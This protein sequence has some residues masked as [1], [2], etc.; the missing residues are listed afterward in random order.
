MHELA[1][2]Q[3]VVAAVRERLGDAPVRAVTL[4]VGA[5]SGVVPDSVRFCFDLCTEG[6]PLAGARL[7]VL[8]IPGR[9]NCRACGA[10]VAMADLF[11]LCP[12]GSADLDVRAGQ[13]LRIKQVEVA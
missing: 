5:L 12:C 1:I 9:G 11:P 7:D 3:S 10:D 4:E 8:E 2:T 13:E 6:T